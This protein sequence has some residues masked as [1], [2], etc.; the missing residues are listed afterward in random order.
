MS[1]AN[2]IELVEN[3]NPTTAPGWPE[4]LAA[5]VVYAGSFGLVAVLLPLIEDDGVA[6]VVGFVVSGLMGLIAFAVAVLIRI[7]GLSAFGMR[8]AKASHLIVGAA[9]GLLAVLLGSIASIAFMMITGEV[10]NVQSTYQAGAAGGVLSLVITLVAGS[11]ITPL[12]EE[13][14]FRGV[15]A[16]ALLA[17]YGAWV[18]IVGSAT[19]GGRIHAAIYAANYVP[20]CN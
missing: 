17:R 6:G 14:L 1:T 7:R 16:N 19:C 4:I 20:V 9:L 8:R 5:G 10:Q 13:A 2:N 12:G 15:I 11:V 18:G 3:R